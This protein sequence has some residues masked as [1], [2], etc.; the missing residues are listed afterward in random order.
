MISEFQISTKLISGRGSIEN[1]GTL[2]KV[3]GASR[4]LVMCDP[5]IEKLG[6]VERL[7]AIIKNAGVEFTVFNKVEPDPTLPVVEAAYES[8][9]NSGADGIIAIGGGSSIDTAKAVAVLGNN[10]GKITDYAGSD[11]IQNPGIPLAVIPTTAG[12]GSEVT[13][14]AVIIDMENKRKFAVRSNYIYPSAA[15]LDPELLVTIPAKV[16]ASTGMDTLTHAIEAYISNKATLITDAFAMK[17]IQLVGSSLASFVADSSNLQAAE[18][19]QAACTMAGAAFN[20]GKVH[21]VH[22]L[23]HALGGHYRMP[24]G[25]A[26][27]VLLPDCMQFML[28]GDM[29]KYRDIAEALGKNVDGLSLRDAAQEAVNA[30][31][32]LSTDIGIPSGLKELGVTEESFEAL[33]KNADSQGIAASSPRRATIADMIEILKAAY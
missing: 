5:L 17:A 27:A 4:V 1:S 25:I 31:R 15:I 18:K 2:L 23:A 22:A 6:L 12:T 33:A 10:P 19:M 7:S 26:N 8:F 9:R 3:L 28:I 29:K 14:I 21:L 30:V 24:H 16:A 20:W 32:E 11:K 13:G